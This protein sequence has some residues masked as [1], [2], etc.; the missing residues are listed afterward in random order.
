MRKTQIRVLKSHYLARWAVLRHNQKHSQKLL[1]IQDQFVLKNLLPGDTL[2]YNCLGEMY[3]TIIP[4][5][6]TTADKKYN[7]LVLINNIEFKYKTPDQLKVLL[8][9]LSEKLLLPNSRIILSFEH[10]FLIY[11][12]IGISVNSLINNW[13]AELKKFKLVSKILLLGKSQP[14]YGDYFFCL[15]YC[16]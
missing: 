2:C 8:E 6:S 14:G 15:D 13:L 11:D 1:L 4:N 7:N 12:R 16:G 3:K 5:L 9:E 10:K